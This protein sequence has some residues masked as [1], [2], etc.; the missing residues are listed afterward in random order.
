MPDRQSVLDFLKEHGGS[1]RDVA[2]AFNLHG[3]NKLA[4]KAM[5]KDLQNDGFVEKTR[6][7]LHAANALPPVAL[8]DLIG[9]DEDGELIAV[10]AEW[11]DSEKAPR[12]L[13]VAAK[14]SDGPAPG[15][16]DRV[17][18]RTEKS[19]ERG[20]DYVARVTKVLS[21]KTSQLLGIFRSM[22]DGSGRLVPIDKKSQGREIDILAADRNGAEDG[23]LVAVE[24]ARE[25]R[26]ARLKARVRERLG[27]IRSEKA[28]SLIAIHAHEIPHV[29]SAAVLNEAEAAK[30]ASLAGREDWR[31]LPLITIDPADAKDHDDAVHAERDTSDGNQGGFVITIA[32]ADVAAYVRPGSALD[33]EALLRGNSV[34]FPDRVVPMLPER[35]SNDLCS[36]RPNEDRPA[37]AVRVVIDKDGR[38]K[39]HSFHR[40]MMRSAAKL[41][42]QQAQAAM[43]G[44]PDD[45]TGPLIRPIL[46]PLYA[47]YDA[48]KKARDNRE[49]LDLDLPERKLLLN[50]DG[51]VKDVITPERLDAH[52]LIEEMMILAN[53]CAAET[54]EKE[55]TH[56]LYRVH[57]A[58]SLDKMENLRQFLET[59]GI[60][61]PRSGSLRPSLFNRVLQRVVGTEHQAIVNEVVLRSQAQAVYAPENLG[62]FGLNLRKYAH[63]TSPIRRYSDLVVHRAI[64]GALLLG[65]DGFKEPNLDKLAKIGEQISAAER[66]AMLAERETIDR[67]IA[68]HLADQIGASFGGRITGVNRAGLFIKLQETG[69]DGFVPIGSLG[70]EYFAYDEASHAVIGTKTGESFRLGD[71]VTVKLV[72]VAPVAGALRFEMVSEG[73]F[74]KTSRINRLSKRGSAAKGGD[75]LRAKAGHKQAMRRKGKRR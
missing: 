1:K 8:L 57:D 61:L 5:L 3:A 59:V 6:K 37:L 65:D 70:N 15:I 44:Q 25:G 18:A 12:V 20:F 26:F 31:S 29:F 27:S 54:L 19:R 16:G 62:H 63:F 21:R 38:K 34:Y 4:L 43:D 58:P 30:P 28:V 9:R 74:L 60:D 36:L 23:D 66:R 10:P 41:A 55:R 39:D 40:I 22:P 50:T 64:I 69:A 52:R 2:R 72:E 33:K 68:H 32:I 73:R 51:T 71:V 35:I 53:V 7:T 48:L 24:A 17:L 11:P 67:L 45:L 42:Y 56:L 46:S 75:A 13:I 49:P 14:R 47:A